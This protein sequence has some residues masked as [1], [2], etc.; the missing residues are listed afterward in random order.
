MTVVL[1]SPVEMHALNTTLLTSEKLGRS[2]PYL[3]CSGSWRGYKLS[4]H[5]G[6]NEASG[7]SLVLTNPPCSI[8]FKLLHFLSVSLSN[9]QLAPAPSKPSECGWEN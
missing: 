8:R 4:V 5:F 2:F 3:E 7:H 9:G 1:I 6:C